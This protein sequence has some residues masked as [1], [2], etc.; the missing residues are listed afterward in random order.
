[1]LYVLGENTQII[2][3]ANG[4]YRIF[5]ETI[6]IAVGNCIERFARVVGLSNDPSLGYNI[7]R[8]ARDWA[9]EHD[10]VARDPLAELPEVVKGIDVSFS[11]L[12]AFIEVGAKHGL[13][14]GS[15]SVGSLCFAL[16][17]KV[18]SM[19]VEVTERA[20]AHC[21]QSDVLCFG[22]VRCN[23]RLQDMLCSMAAQRGGRDFCTDGRFCIAAK[24]RARRARVAPTDSASCA[25]A[26]RHASARLTV[27]VMQ[28]VPVPLLPRSARAQTCCSHRTP[29]RPPYAHRTSTGRATRA[30]PSVLARPSWTTRSASTTPLSPPAAARRAAQQNR[31][32][33]HPLR[34]RA[35]NR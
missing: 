34:R 21:G 31:V 10:G 24:Q 30:R 2:A 35:A 22:G 18:C 33:P 8:S 19:L 32:A 26:A 11:G 12:L 4:R 16:Q 13:R 9:R 5:G 23:T 14:D 7:E 25:R 27:V 1:M 6:D 29:L 20:M 28:E 3:Y 17:E 15:H